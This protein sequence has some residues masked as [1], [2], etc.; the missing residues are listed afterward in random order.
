MLA[1]DG[2]IGGIEPGKASV[3][4]LFAINLQSK[5]EDR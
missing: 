5:L 3:L 2:F 1:V 4:F